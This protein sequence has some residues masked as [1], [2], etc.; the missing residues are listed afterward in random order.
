MR[1]GKQIVY[2]EIRTTKGVIMKVKWFLSKTVWILLIGQIG[3]ALIIYKNVDWTNFK[4]IIDT[5]F[6]ET[7]IELMAG[8]FVALLGQIFRVNPQAEQKTT[9]YKKNRGEPI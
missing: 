2:V 3:A 8:I 6:I 1:R 7:N 9:Q 5:L 4:T